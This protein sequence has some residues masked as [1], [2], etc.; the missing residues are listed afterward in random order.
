MENSGY[1]FHLEPPN[2]MLGIGIHKFSKSILKA[3]RLAV[4]DPHM[5]LELERAVQSM[6]KK[7]GYI[8]GSKHYKRVP[9][10]FDPDDQR[11]VF[12]KYNGLFCSNERTIPEAFQSAR[13]IDYCLEIYREMS[14]I[15]TWLMDVLESFQMQ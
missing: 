9:R 12:L 3:Y 4:I 7:T 8:I 6:E 1:Y 2:L 10:G 11:A 13:L 5:G 15:H 14:P